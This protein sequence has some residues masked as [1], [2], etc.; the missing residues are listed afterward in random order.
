MMVTKEMER[1]RN[2]EICVNGVHLGTIS[3]F[4]NADGSLKCSITVWK[5]GTV[6]KRK[7]GG[8]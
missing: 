7:K 8:E 4:Y 3:Y 6:T 2:E 5:D 1:I